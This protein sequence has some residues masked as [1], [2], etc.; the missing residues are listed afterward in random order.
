MQN[1]LLLVSGGS[2]SEHAEISVDFDTGAVV[3]R[4]YGLGSTAS[5]SPKMSL[6]RAASDEIATLRH[7]SDQLD[8]DEI[9]RDACPNAPNSKFPGMPPLP[10]M[11]SMDSIQWLYIVR[12]GVRYGGIMRGEYCQTEATKRVLEHIRS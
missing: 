5:V 11:P 3:T 8:P 2:I 9:S 4:S 10:K 6:R 1:G 12:D 7:L